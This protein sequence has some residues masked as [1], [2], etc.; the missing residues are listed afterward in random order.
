MPGKDTD[1]PQAKM[2]AVRGGAMPVY[3]ATCFVLAVSII[4]SAT[5]AP[6]WF[7]MQAPRFLA[8]LTFLLSV[9]VGFAL[10]SAFIWFAKLLGEISPKN[11]SIGLKR[12]TFS[13]G[14]SAL[15]FIILVMSAPDL[16]SD[17][18]FYP[19]GQR[20]SID[21]LDGSQL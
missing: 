9:P 18:A 1:G 20:R 7:P 5:V 14:T 8:T 12:T 16:G 13:L 4:F 2:P 15:I 3:L 19:K 6:S 21:D 11:A 17:Y 10:V